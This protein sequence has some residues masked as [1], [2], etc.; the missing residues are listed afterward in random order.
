MTMDEY[1]DEPGEFKHLKIK[2]E[3]PEIKNGKHFSYFGKVVT[4]LYF[5]YKFARI[6]Y[7]INFFRSNEAT[8]LLVYATLF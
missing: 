3:N 2:A 8:L 7:G 1:Q 5:H 4:W 6:G